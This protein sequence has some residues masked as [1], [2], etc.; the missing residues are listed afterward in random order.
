MTSTLLPFI[1]GLFAAVLLCGLAFVIWQRRQREQEPE[2]RDA[3]MPERAGTSD[4]F[5]Q[6]WSQ[7]L[8]DIMEWKRYE[9]LVVAY[10]GELGFETKTVGVSHDGVLVMEGYERGTTQAVMLVHCKAWNR[11]PVD[12][13]AMRALRDRMDTAKIG[14]GAYFNTGGFAPA[15]VTLAGGANI[16]VVNGRELLERVAQLPLERQNALLDLAT[17]GEYGTPTCPACAVKMVRRVTVTGAQAGVYF[18]G[19]ANHPSCKRTFPVRK[20]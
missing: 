6:Y 13:P 8:L 9:E 5:A 7:R 2:V 11:T 19:C 15:A 3:P 12:E 14:Q 1:A 10:I 18:W 4:P 17:D 20:E 16:D